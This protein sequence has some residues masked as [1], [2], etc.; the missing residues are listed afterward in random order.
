M[1]FSLC[2]ADDPFP[3]FLAA[4]L[5]VAEHEQAGV[6]VHGFE[7]HAEG[8]ADLGMGDLFVVLVAPFV[9]VDDAF[10]FVADIDDDMVVVDFA[11]FAFDNLVRL[12]ILAFASG[13]VSEFLRRRTRD[14][15]I[16]ASSSSSSTS[17]LRSRLRFTMRYGPC[18]Y[19]R[20]RALPEKKEGFCEASHYRHGSASQASHLLDYS[21]LP[22]NWLEEVG[23]EGG[24]WTFIGTI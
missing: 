15:E 9:E 14:S 1:S 24:E 2:R 20:A 12:V 11:D 18:P 7:Q 23:G 19:G 6:V 4:G 16:R 17:Y 10:A 8:V 3:F 22:F 13:K 5:L 21:P